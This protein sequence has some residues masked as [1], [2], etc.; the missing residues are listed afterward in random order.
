[1]EY[2]DKAQR[3]TVTL[4]PNMLDSLKERIKLG[5]YASMSELIREAVRTWTQREDEQQA[6]LELIKA[7]LE[8]SANSGDPIPLKKAFSSIDD[9]HQKYLDMS[10]E[11][12]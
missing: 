4:P 3:I 7:R 2:A 5:E 6:R 10:D 9:L 11:K 1:M 12:L 8:H